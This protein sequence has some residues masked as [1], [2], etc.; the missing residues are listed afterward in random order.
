MEG[1]ENS[2]RECERLRRL[3]NTNFGKARV[4]VRIRCEE[5]EPKEKIQAYQ[6]FYRRLAQACSMKRST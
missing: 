6:E 3:L 1:K 5:M 4:I 2:P